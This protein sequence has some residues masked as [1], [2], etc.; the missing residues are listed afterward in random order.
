MR[1]HV[2]HFVFSVFERLFRQQKCHVMTALVA[3]NYQNAINY[4]KTTK[5]GLKNE[6][7]IKLFR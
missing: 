6:R 1:Q 5:S 7:I 3:N 2:F 4:H